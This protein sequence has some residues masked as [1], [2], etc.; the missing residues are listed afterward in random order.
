MKCQRFGSRAVASLHGE[1]KCFLCDWQPP[2]DF[3]EL[4]PVTDAARRLDVAVRTVRRWIDAG[5]VQGDPPTGSGHVRMVEIVSL[6]GYIEERRAALR[7]CE[8]CGLDIPP[9][10]IKQSSRITR[11]WC[12][13]TTNPNCKKRGHRR[14]RRAAA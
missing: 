3:V 4:V 8:W 14:A 2:S 9:A 13:A 5:M 7:T 1:I 12:A 10:G 6:A 11:R